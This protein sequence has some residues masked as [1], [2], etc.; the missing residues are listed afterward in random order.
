MRACFWFLIFCRLESEGGT[1]SIRMDCP[2]TAIGVRASRPR[3]PLA[4]QNPFPVA[5]L[6][7]FKGTIAGSCGV[8][9]IGLW[10]KVESP[11]LRMVSPKRRKHSVAFFAL[12][13]TGKSFSGGL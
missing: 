2:R 11:A 6:T 3:F 1:P 10:N 5:F 8:H 9:L 12:S 7:G 4:P 13:Y